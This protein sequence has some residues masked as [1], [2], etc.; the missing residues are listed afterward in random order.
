MMGKATRDALINLSP[1]DIDRPQTLMVML[2]QGLT[3]LPPP[4]YLNNPL[5]KEIGIPLPGR[6]VREEAVNEVGLREQH[7]AAAGA[8]EQSPRR[9]G[10]FTHYKILGKWATWPICIKI[11]R[12][13]FS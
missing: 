6:Q 3:V 7:R 13:L 5:F 2:C 1:T 12:M 11:I 8:Q 9:L 10:R 4:L